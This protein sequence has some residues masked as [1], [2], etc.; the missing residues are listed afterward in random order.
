MSETRNTDGRVLTDGGPSGG[1]GRWVSLGVATYLV[2]SLGTVASFY[3]LVLAASA[4]DSGA[5]GVGGPGGIGL[6]GDGGL[7]G[8]IGIGLAA[9]VFLGAGLATA[10]GLY[11]GR[12]VGSG[13]SAPAA[14]AASTGAGAFV[15]AAILFVFFLV[16]DGGASGGDEVLPAVGAI[17]GLSVGVAITGAAAAAVG[18]RAGTW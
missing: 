1:M 13:E 11:I 18:Q 4:L 17:V 8:A 3:L 5:G 7:A 2:A 15:A 9:I 10:L 6:F 16:L 12:T 14:G